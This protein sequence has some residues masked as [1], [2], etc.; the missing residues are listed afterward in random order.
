MPHSGTAAEISTKTPSHRKTPHQKRKHTY[1]GNINKETRNYQNTVNLHIETVLSSYASLNDEASRFPKDR[2]TQ[3]SGGAVE[4][5]RKIC[6]IPIL[7]GQAK[8]WR[9]REKPVTLISAASPWREK[10]EG[11]DDLNGGLSD[12]LSADPSE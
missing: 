4:S 11:L 8:Q 2:P 12:R 5:K 10:E 9:E 7:T 3:G 1:P 6:E